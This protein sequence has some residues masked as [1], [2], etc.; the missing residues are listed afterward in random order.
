MTLEE[1]LEE[2]A[3]ESS[4]EDFS[5]QLISFEDA[6]EEKALPS[7]VDIPA[8]FKAGLELQ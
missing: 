6:L 5:E 4:Q 2:K 7:E 8:F 3:T 1:A